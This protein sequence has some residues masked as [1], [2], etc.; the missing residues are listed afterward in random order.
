MSLFLF[1]VSNI[2]IT[3]IK[4]KENIIHIRVKGVDSLLI[5]KILSNIQTHK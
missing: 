4:K 1:I 5:E 2:H 3:I